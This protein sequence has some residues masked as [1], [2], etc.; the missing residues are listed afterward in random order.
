MASYLF[1][2]LHPYTPTCSLHSSDAHPLSTPPVRLCNVGDRA[3]SVAG[4]Y[5]WNPQGLHQS[6]SVASFKLQLKT[7]PFTLAFPGALSCAHL[8]L[9]FYLYIHILL[10][11]LLFFSVII[12]IIL[13]LFFPLLSFIM[14]WCCIMYYYVCIYICFDCLIK[15]CKVSLGDLK[16]T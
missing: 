4:P 6:T 14:Y 12:I 16:S 13:S 5:F 10:L 11:L 7:Y 3:F 1:T 2:L 8:N 9:F 15:I